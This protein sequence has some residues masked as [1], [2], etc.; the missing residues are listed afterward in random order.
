M[1]IDMLMEEYSSPF[2]S[3]YGSVAM[4]RIFSEK[5]RRLTWRRIW[6]ALAE[7]AAQTRPGD[8]RTGGGFAGACAR[9]VHRARAGNREGNRPRCD[10]RGARFRRTLPGGRGDHPLGGD[11]GR[12]HRQRRRAADAGCA[13]SAAGQAP[14]AALGPR[15]ADRTP[16]R[17]GGAGIHPFT[18]GRTDHARLPAGAVRAGRARTLPGTAPR[19]GR[20]ARQG[21][22]RRGGNRRLLRRDS[23]RQE[24]FPRCASTRR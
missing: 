13:R 5:N 12:H 7:A 4:R 22:E 10:G 14:H 19:A 8:G 18:A 15:G 9:R 11:L 23:Q 24:Y 3:R 17:S 6:I 1:D 16:F 21:D 2:S 20:T